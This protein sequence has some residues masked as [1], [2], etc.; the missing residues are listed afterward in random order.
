M[1]KKQDAARYSGAS[2]F[3]DN[4][5]AHYST[6]SEKPTEPQLIIVM[7]WVYSLHPSIRI[8]G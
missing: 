8:K 4:N 6:I 5:K 3:A 7:G 2:V 1:G